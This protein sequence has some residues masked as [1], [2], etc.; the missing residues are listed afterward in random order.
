MSEL[1][2]RILHHDGTEEVRDLVRGDLT[3]GR[4]A[5][6]EIRPV[7]P[8]LSRHHAVIHG[9][10]TPPTIEDLKTR[11]G[12]MVNGELVNSI[13]TLG[14]GDVVEL[15]STTIEVAG[16][17]DSG[18]T[19]RSQPTVE[20]A[21]LPP[22]DGIVARSPK[23]LELLDRADR[24]ARSDLP[25]LIT[26]ETGTGKEL[27]A[28]RIHRVSQRAKGPF[29]IL[30]CPAL[31][32]GLV[33][34]ELFGVEEGVATGVRAR[35]GRLLEADGGT[36]F[37]DEVGD[38]G[39]DV[40]AKLL[41]FLQE[42]TVEAVGGRVPITLDVRVVAATNQDLEKTI[43]AG[44][45][46]RDLFFRIVGARLDIPPLRER[47]EDILPLVD[48]LLGRR[49][50]GRFRLDDDAIAV[51]KRHA[52]PGNVRELATA[53]GRAAVMAKSGVIRLADLAL[54]TGMAS[55]D[56][57]GTPSDLLESLI[58]GDADFWRDV[59]TPF[60]ERELSRS[61]VRALVECGLERTGGSIKDFAALIGE[62]SAYRKLLD[63]LRNNRL[64]P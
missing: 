58:A 13:V 30:N 49:N 44:G 64:L 1:V 37:L 42:G 11:N 19:R 12:T 46:R 31:A 57:V 5:D 60:M 27:F 9:E 63:F 29:V 53:L 52:F 3:I 23:M 62:K 10:A 28:A 35:P 7:D 24:F 18:D 32:E 51:L 39:L 6:N 59:H 16:R 20:L 33:E 50:L 47:A 40:Q 41:R 14:P 8:A 48:H 4:E 43:D 17:G 22:D 55:A 38:L 54:G 34:S 26:G 45:F 56:A 25:I 21:E 2:L 15:G 61:T 36:L